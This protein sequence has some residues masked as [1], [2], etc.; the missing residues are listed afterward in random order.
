MEFLIPNTWSL[1]A[2][3]AGCVL[4]CWI[5]Y[6]L[7]P[8]K[9]RKNTGLFHYGLM[10]GLGYL[11]F[12]AI[13]ARF[14]LFESESQVPHKVA[15]QDVHNSTELPQWVIMVVREPLH[16]RECAGTHC[17]SVYVLQEG[18]KVSVDLASNKN[19]W[20]K[21]KTELHEGYASSLWL[22]K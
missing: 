22:H 12:I 9:L 6:Q 16:I 1:G 4:C 11:G 5:I 8:F 10:L 3:L 2:I 13:G 14:E 7:L 18:D 15:M 21:I 20:L 19:N 17:R